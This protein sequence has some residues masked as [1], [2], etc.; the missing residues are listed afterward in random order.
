[1]KLDDFYVACMV[2]YRSI[3]I[4]MPDFFSDMWENN[5]KDTK[6]PYAK[7]QQLLEETEFIPKADCLY[8]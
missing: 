7:L 2:K 3:I 6:L 4:L 5:N 8:S 1:M